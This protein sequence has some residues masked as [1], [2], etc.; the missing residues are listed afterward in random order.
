MKAVWVV[1]EGFQTWTLKW[2]WSTCSIL[3]MTPLCN[4]VVLWFTVQED[5]WFLK[6]FR[7]YWASFKWKIWNIL[8]SV[9]P[10][11]KKTFKTKQF[12][13]FRGRGNEHKINIQTAL[14][15]LIMWSLCIF[16]ACVI[17]NIVSV[18]CSSPMQCSSELIFAKTVFY[19]AA[20]IYCS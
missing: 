5:F 14:M 20:V 10:I 7:P 4:K 9:A 15:L 6:S 13:A 18:K 2:L 1:E 11:F 17:F 8:N 16:E 3:N 19:N 12:W